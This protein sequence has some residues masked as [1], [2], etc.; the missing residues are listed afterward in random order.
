LVRAHNTTIDG[1]PVAVVPA[2]V[3]AEIA[4][5]V[6]RAFERMPADWVPRRELGDAVSV[7][8]MA[9][10]AVPRSDI[11]PG[12]QGS[13][14]T[15]GHITSLELAVSANVSPRHVTRLAAR[16]ERGPFPGARLAG[17]VWLIPADEADQWKR[18]RD[19]R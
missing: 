19:R 4:R 11:G 6:E 14:D 12:G 18:D 2:D 8:R 10:L 7:M 5:I 15:G 17:G 16:A 3:A 13:P 9:P 1:E